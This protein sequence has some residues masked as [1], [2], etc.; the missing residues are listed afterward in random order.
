MIV[1]S[2][3]CEYIMAWIEPSGLFALLSLSMVFGF[4]FNVGFVKETAGLTDREK[5]SL[6]APHPTHQSV[7]MTTSVED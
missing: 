3:T 6:Y 7:E 2:S 5:K 4:L 1:L